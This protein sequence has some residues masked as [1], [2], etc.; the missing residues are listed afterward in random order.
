M[1]SKETAERVRLCKNYFDEMLERASSANADLEDAR[2][3]LSEAEAAWSREFFAQ[4]K[5][6]A[7][8]KE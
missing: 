3:K 4:D 5:S 6:D 2:R 8:S 7:N 1:V